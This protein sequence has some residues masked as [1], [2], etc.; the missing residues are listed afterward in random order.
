VKLLG[1]K[2]AVKA[3]GGRHWITAILMGEEGSERTR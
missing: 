1:G 2:R 3:I